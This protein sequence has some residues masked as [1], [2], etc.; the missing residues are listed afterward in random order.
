MGAVHCVPVFDIM[1]VT[2]TPSSYVIACQQHIY[3][4]LPDAGGEKHLHRRLDI[5]ASS[6]TY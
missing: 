1:L 5:K 3:C 6:I 2:V 4:R